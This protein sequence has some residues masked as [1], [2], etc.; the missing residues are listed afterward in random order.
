MRKEGLEY[1]VLK[2]NPRTRTVVRTRLWEW[3]PNNKRGPRVEW[4]G[5]V[6]YLDVPQF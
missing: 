3:R 6:H 1:W 2:Y 4:L 5:A